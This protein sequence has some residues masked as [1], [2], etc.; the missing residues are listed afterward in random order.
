MRTKM[1]A[2]VGLMVLAG[3]PGALA[4]QEEHP[5]QVSLLSPIQAFPEE[6]AVRGLRLSILYGRNMDVTG[7]D[8]GLVSHV[9]RDFTGV[10]WGLVGFV[11]GDAL[12]VQSNQFVNIVEGELEGVQIGALNMADR[13]QGLQLSLVSH[14]RN[15][16]GLQIGLVNYAETLK[17][18]QIGLVNIIRSGGVLPVMPLVNWSSGG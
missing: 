10:Q 9:S 13:G 12:G 14:A 2:I 4:A 5:F 18:I 3:V 8:I 15:F 11:E 17:G 1:V 16:Q 7:V 6:D